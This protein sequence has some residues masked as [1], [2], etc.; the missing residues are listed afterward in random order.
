MAPLWVHLLNRSPH[1][2][3]REFS[4]LFLLIDACNSISG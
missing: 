3:I 1:N 4:P 2:P